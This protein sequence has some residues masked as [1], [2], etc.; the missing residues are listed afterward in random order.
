M[1]K[2]NID[3]TTGAKIQNKSGHKLEANVVRDTPSPKKIEGKDLAVTPLMI[4]LDRIDSTKDKTF[5]YVRAFAWYVRMWLSTVYT[6]SLD[7]KTSLRVLLLVS[8][9]M[10]NNGTMTISLIFGNQ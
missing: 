7:T 1:A 6:K 10:S 4:T 2:M 9:E 8:N 5:A 3:S